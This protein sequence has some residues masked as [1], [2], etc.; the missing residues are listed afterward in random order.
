[1][2]CTC[3]LLLFSSELQVNYLPHHLCDAD[4][5]AMVLEHKQA[6]GMGLRSASAD[7]AQNT[8]CTYW[9]WKVHPMLVTRVESVHLWAAVYS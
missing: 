8:D 7:S 4:W 3:L 2:A 5:E 9:L 6:E 1:M